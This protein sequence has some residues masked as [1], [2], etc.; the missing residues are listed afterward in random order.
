LIP[1]FGCGYFLVNPDELKQE[2]KTIGGLKWKFPKYIKTSKALKQVY[3]I[4]VMD[5][6][7]MVGPL[8]QANVPEV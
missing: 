7:T 2:I 1:K 4:L 3:D 8:F 5:N 6:N